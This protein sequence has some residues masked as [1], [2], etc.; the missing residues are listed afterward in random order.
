MGLFR[1][2]TPTPASATASAPVDV[3]GRPLE[4]GKQYVITRERRDP[5]AATL[6]VSYQSIS[7]PMI[8]E[9]DAETAVRWAYIANTYVYRCVD[10]IASAISACPF[11]AGPDPRKRGEFDETV[12]L[13]RLLGPPPGSPNPEV[14]PRRLWKWTVAQRLITGRWFWEIERVNPSNPRGEVL[15]LWP[16]PAHLI[17]PIISDGGR[18]Y[19]KGFV[20]GRHLGGKQRY[21]AREQVVY[22]WNPS[23]LDFR[24]P[25][26]VLQAAR[27]DVSVA[28]MQDRYDVAFLKNDARPAAVIVHE[29]FAE[30]EEREAFRSQFLAEFRGVDNAG[31]PIFVEATPGDEEINRTFHIERLGLSQKDAEF[32]PRYEAKIRAICV[33][34]GTPLSILGDSSARTFSNAEQEYRNWWEA[35]L[36]PLMAEFEDAVNIRLAPLVGREV[37]W[38]DTSGVAALQSQSRI[39]ALGAGVQGLLD[40]VFTVD[41]VRNE[42]GLAPLDDVLTADEKAFRDAQR[43]AD[44]A[45]MKAATQTTTPVTP[46]EP[47]A[48]AAQTG[49]T[50]GDTT[51]TP[52]STPAPDAGTRSMI[53]DLAAYDVRHVKIVE[54]RDGRLVVEQV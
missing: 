53:V 17:D 20:Y 33:A 36:L 7:A 23:Q 40:T 4:V 29:E 15:G 11:R 37:G 6:S 41:E 54:D 50:N 12:K 3:D 1:K 24:Q 14:S 38:F 35:T 19:F 45:R 25:E 13:A 48:P 52:V 8:S 31:K 22:D 42:Y 18:Q 9:W 32:I 51:G 10:M 21:L 39:V 34:F 5:S 44:L 47:V 27:L 28:V 30:R 16:L 46:V 26:S 43:E 2:T 49:N